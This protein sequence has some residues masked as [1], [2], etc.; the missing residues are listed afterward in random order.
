MN[1]PHYEPTINLG[2]V[3]TIVSIM[4]LGVPS[5]IWLWNISAAQATFQANVES[6]LTIGEKVRAEKLPQIDAMQRDV[7]RTND[8]LTIHRD[9][10]DGLLE[11]DR[12]LLMKI[13]EIRE[14]LGILETTIK[15]KPAQES[16]RP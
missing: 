14:R 9:T 11:V 1:T 2:H 15:L 8:R 10:L 4:A 3:L 7:D 13:G 12:A 6:R 5:I 16:F